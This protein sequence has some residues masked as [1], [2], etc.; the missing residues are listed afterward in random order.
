MKV[1]QIETLFNE[2]WIS[3]DW[4]KQGPSNHKVFLTAKS[5]EILKG[6]GEILKL[7][8]IKRKP[9]LAFFQCNILINPLNR[10]SFNQ[11]IHE[12]IKKNVGKMADKSY[13]RSHNFRIGF[14]TTLWKDTSD[15]E[16]IR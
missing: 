9:F 6:K 3:I 15:I 16:F 5:I 2:S 12:F 1:Y 10:I 13:I 8:Y 7:F 14:I 11:I 4:A